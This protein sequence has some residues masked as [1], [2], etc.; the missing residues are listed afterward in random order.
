MNFHWSVYSEEPYSGL[1]SSTEERPRQ[2]FFFST[3]IFGIH[4]MLL[5]YFR[6]IQL[7]GFTSSKQAL[8]NFEVGL[9]K[10]W[11]TL[12]DLKLLHEYFSA[13]SLFP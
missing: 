1:C 10:C 8:D 11:Y 4:H 5:D 7:R 9:G 13:E 12:R 3:I 2:G 6:G